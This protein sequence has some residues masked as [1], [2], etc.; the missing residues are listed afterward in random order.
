MILTRTYMYTLLRRC[1]IMTC[2]AVDR[3][4]SLQFII[5]LRYIIHVYHH[6]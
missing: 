1:I 3:A 6:V 5:D 2:Q 4:C